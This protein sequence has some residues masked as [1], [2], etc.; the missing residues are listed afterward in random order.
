MTIVIPAKN[1]ADNISFLL[2][3]LYRQ[4][5]SRGIRVIVA[6]GGSTDGTQGI[7]EHYAKQYADRLQ[8]ELIEGGSVSR[9]RN[10]GL[11]LVTTP[12]VIFIDADVQLLSA[13]HLSDTHR[14]LLRYYLVGSP[15]ASRGEWRSRWAYR[16]F[17]FCAKA[18][19]PFHSFAVG[20]FFA[21]RTKIVKRLGGFREDLVHSEDWALSKRFPPKKFTHTR[22]PVQVDDRR[23]RKTGYLGMLGL[24]FKSAII[25]EAYWKTDNGYWK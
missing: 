11:A 7:V 2:T 10:A 17:N 19:K 4:Q 8:I 21:T 14:L 12:Y 6:D 3:D 5:A 18:V 16:L 25:G 15:L 24:I 1:E 9:G 13:S 20:S 23:F 22:R